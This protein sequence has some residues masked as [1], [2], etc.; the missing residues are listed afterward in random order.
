MT[1]I[2]QCSLDYL[3]LV[4][5]YPPADTKKEV[6]QWQE[7]GGGPVATA[8]VTL[9]RLGIRCRFHGV[10]G[11]DDAGEK[12]RRSLTREGVDVRGIVARHSAVSQVA[13]IVV[14]LKTASRTIFWRRPSGEALRTEELPVNFLENSSFLLL[15]GLMK[16][17]SLYAA[18]KAKTSGIPVMLDAGRMRP[19][20]EQLARCSDYVVASEEF[21]RDLGLE[22][23]GEALQRERAGLGTR[24]LTVTLGEKGSITASAEEEF[25]TP[26]F[27]T[28]AVDTTGAGDVFH[29][30]YI[31]GLLR[32]LSLRDAVT[33][34]SAVAALKCRKTGG[35]AGIPRLNEVME[36][37]REKGPSL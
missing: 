15:D 25:A 8:L 3:G 17:V 12:I 19:G 31:H 26:A 27:K 36:F 11:D 29:G 13:F 24:A 2:G 16:D 28:E 7:E 34:A 30:G 9:S 1:G 23:T 10:I 6:L 35:R 20:M 32:G 33:F 22:L 4:D 37:L 21:A 18:Q 14:E 5:E